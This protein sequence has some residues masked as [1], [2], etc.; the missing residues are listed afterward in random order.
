MPAPSISRGINAGNLL[1]KQ[2]WYHTTTWH[3]TTLLSITRRSSP[4]TQLQTFHSK[5]HT[6]YRIFPV[7][8]GHSSSSSSASASVVQKHNLEHHQK[9]YFLFAFNTRGHRQAS[10][11]EHT[12]FYILL[13]L[14]SHCNTSWHRLASHHWTFGAGFGCS[15]SKQ[16]TTAHSVWTL[17]TT[18]LCIL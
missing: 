11:T 14:A 13:L 10:I 3:S 7:R 17:R 9:F 4:L 2:L 1:T 5:L 15:S 12:R 18:L 16:G 6:L 8:E